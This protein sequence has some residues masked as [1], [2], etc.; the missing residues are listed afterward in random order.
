M[1]N[2]SQIQFLIDEIVCALDFRECSGLGE[3]GIGK[4]RNSS[5]RRNAALQIRKHNRRICFLLVP[6]LP[7]RAFR[8]PVY[9]LLEL[10]VCEVPITNSE[11]T[12]QAETP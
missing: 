12:I 6:G 9:R 3:R 4:I 7:A 1:K 2:A 5:V 8:E 10:R 11:F